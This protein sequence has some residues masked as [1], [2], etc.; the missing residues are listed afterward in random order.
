MIL[1]PL[2]GEYIAS[3]I[4]RG[5]ET[6]GIKG[7]NK[8][9]YYIKRKANAKNQLK[10]EDLIEFPTIFEKHKVTEEVLYQN[11]L[12]PLAAALG[13]TQAYCVYTPTTSWKICLNCVVEDIQIHG[14]A[15]IH[16][17]NLLTSVSVCSVHASKLYE[18]CPACL[19]SIT[20][21]EIQKLVQCSKFFQ[22]TQLLIGSPPHFYAK[23]V[24][25]LLDYDK[26]TFTQL[27]AEIMIIMKLQTM[28]YLDSF[29]GL[30]IDTLKIDI[31]NQLSFNSKFQYFHC[32]TLNVCATSAFL[33]YQTADEYLTAMKDDS[34]GK[35]LQEKVQELR[36]IT[37]KQRMLPIR[38]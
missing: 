9:D 17:R 23:L 21:H 18:R 5:N 30:D 35:K 14:T 28:G 24:R 8:D 10:E 3:A 27:H 13:R 32:L 33:A 6:L 12:Y 22:V 38:K 2:P 7:V 26:K 29:G 19:K 15:Y 16:R 34:A 20:S 1:A 31:K 4:R 25:K 36:T 11:T 37:F